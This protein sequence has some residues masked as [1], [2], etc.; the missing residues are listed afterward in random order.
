M[1]LEWTTW[2]RLSEK[3]GPVGILPHRGPKPPAAAQKRRRAAGG[4]ESGNSSSE[5]EEDDDDDDDDDSESPAEPLI[6]RPRN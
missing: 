4:V 3:F 6:R 2:K 1:S 5:E